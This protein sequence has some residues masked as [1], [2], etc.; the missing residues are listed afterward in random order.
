MFTLFQDPFYYRPTYWYRAPRQPSLFER[1]LDALDQ[2]FLSVLGDE[3]AEARAEQPSSAAP[4]TSDAPPVEKP[5]QRAIQQYQGF[6]R[7]SG[8]DG[9][10]YVEEHRERVT[11]SQGEVRIVT[12]RRLGDRWYENEVLI[13]KEGKK[14]E[15]ETWHNVGDDEI[16]KF[17]LEWSERSTKKEI[18]GPEAAAA[19][20]PAPAPA[21]APPVE[22]GKE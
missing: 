15:R 21:A 3:A 16:E 10:G 9:R 5:A 1:Y 13:D 7:E 18:K 22:G 6:G 19:P 17:K 11:G 4:P 12:R 2:R 8:L 20:A 14:T